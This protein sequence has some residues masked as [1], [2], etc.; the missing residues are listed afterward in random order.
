M[1]MRAAFGFKIHTGW[2]MLVA[3]AGQPDQIEVLIRRRI[4][5][6]P[7]DESI[8]RFAYHAAAKLPLTGATELIKRVERESRRSAQLTIESAIEELGG[9]NARVNTCGV[10]SGSTLV[11]DDLSR[12]LQSHPLIHAAEGTLFVKS[13]VSACKALAIKTISVHDREIWDRAATSWELSEQN[14]RKRI[15]DVRKSVGSPWSADH[16]LAT[17]T[18]LFALKA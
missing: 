18:A 4:E 16:K 1:P 7:R 3:V 11:P 2:A 9:R 13:I 10:L 14:L 17:A 5:L 12:I 6:L 15:D 8:P